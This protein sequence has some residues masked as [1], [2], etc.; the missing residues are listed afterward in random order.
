MLRHGGRALLL[1][2]DAISNCRAEID[3]EFF[4][5]RLLY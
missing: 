1:R 2:H 4:E 5:V 3:K